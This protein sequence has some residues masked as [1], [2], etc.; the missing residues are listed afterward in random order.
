MEIIES[1]MEFE[2]DQN[3]SHDLKS[4]IKETAITRI[5]RSLKILKKNLKNILTAEKFTNQILAVFQ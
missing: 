3:Y 4:F 1:Q 5:K 2:L